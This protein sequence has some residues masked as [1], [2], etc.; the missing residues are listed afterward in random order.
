MTQS[1]TRKTALAF[2]DAYADPDIEKRLY[3]DVWADRTG[4]SVAEK[5]QV[6]REVR[7][8]TYRFA[9]QKREVTRK[10]KAASRPGFM[11]M[12]EPNRGGVPAPE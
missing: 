12:A 5:H 10:S 3:F 1:R 11:G 7:R 9:A 8:M 4:L 6:W 2:F